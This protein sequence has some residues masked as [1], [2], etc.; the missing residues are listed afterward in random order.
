[1]IFNGAGR[2][3]NGADVIIAI[4]EEWLRVRVLKTSTYTDIKAKISAVDY[5]I[6]G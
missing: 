6:S 1:V 2:D 5:F 4:A 3:C